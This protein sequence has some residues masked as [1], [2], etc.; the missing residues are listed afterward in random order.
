[1]AV[2]V[3]A[4]IKGGEGAST[5]VC[6]FAVYL[7]KQGKDVL[8]VDADLNNE[9][10]HLF[11]LQR[12][13]ALEGDAGY[14]CIRLE[15]KSVRHEVL[16]MKDKYDDIIIDVGAKDSSSLRAAFTV[17]DRFIV[18]FCPSVFDMW[19]LEKIEAV[20]EEMEITNS[21]IQCYSFLNKVDP[22]KIDKRTKG[23]RYT[24]DTLAAMEVLQE[25]KLLCYLPAPTAYRKVFQ[26]A[27]AQ[28]LGITESKDK[29][30][31]QEVMKLYDFIINKSPNGS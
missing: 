9:S 23:I 21:T 18:P 5:H 19:T 30:A 10:A 2:Y 7:S 20:I 14:S 31:I 27:P 6:S 4:K 16:R 12:D 1:M 17:G 25:S 3:F 11:T 29:K 15:G 22:P 13:Q 26:H 8:V 24:N 28:G